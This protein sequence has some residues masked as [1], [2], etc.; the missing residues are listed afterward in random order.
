M[1]PRRHRL[2]TRVVPI[3]VLLAAPAEAAAQ[4]P[5]TLCLSLTQ[6][7]ERALGK[8]EEIATAR[9]RV[10]QADARVTQAT[11]A[12]LPQLT[13]SLTYNRA[14]YSQFSALEG[15]AGADTSSIPSAF[16]PTLPARVRYDTLSSLLMADFMAGLAKGLPFG[17]ANTYMSLVQVSQ[18][19]FAG[20]RI[21]AA[22]S[23]AQHAQAASEHQL[24]ETEA[25]MVLQ[26]RV[27][28]LNVVLA[29]R[30][31]AIAVDARRIAAEHLS[32]VEL[33]RQAGTASQFDLLRAR[34]DLEN[35]E[36]GVVQAENLAR[37]A[38]LE[39]KRLTNLPTDAPVT[40]TSTFDTQPVEV[41]EAALT[42]L[43]ADRPALLAAREMVALRRAGLK[44]ARGEW[45]P[46]LAAQAN[47]AFYAYPGT[48]APPA[49]N[50][51]LKDWSVA[52]AVSWPL[53]D[54]FARNGRV[55]EASAALSEA[56]EQQA[57]L[58]EG[59]RVELSQ[60]VGDYRTAVAQLKARQET[61]RLAQEAHDLADLRYRNGLATQLEVSDAALVLDQARVNEVQALA[62]YVKALARLE[63]LGGGRLTLLREAQP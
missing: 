45:F 19:L 62:D 16:D 35:R 55:S 49:F 7:V 46:T 53:F 12:A 44:S 24:A 34:V 60:A 38:M 61:S 18:P 52:L 14:I 23:M 54:G 50:Q 58:E 1:T 43:V 17:R 33:F 36:P 59:M 28:Y 41:D 9:A 63:R 10:S 48:V 6:A 56:T 40:L 13:A 20:G 25:D 39:L 22:R 51:W 37:V 29:Q 11:A 27:A 3:C 15:F 8:S 26:V 47:L 4:T 30:L 42:N 32:Q 31:R 57:M 21:S 5:D 2:V